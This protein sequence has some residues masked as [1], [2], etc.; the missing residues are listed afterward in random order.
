[1][2]FFSDG[3]PIKIKLKIL[4][5]YTVPLAQTFQLKNGDHYKL[6]NA[7]VLRNK[8]CGAK[9][10]ALK[11][12]AFFRGAFNKYEDTSMKIT[13]ADGNITKSIEDQMDV[14]LP[15]P[16]FNVFFIRVI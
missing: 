12:V 15:K 3:G 8:F 14:M 10:Q 1:M 11:I 4:V 2:N 5:S 13:I 7:K 6:V 9:H 16:F